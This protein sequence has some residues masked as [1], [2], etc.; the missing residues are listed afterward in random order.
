MKKALLVI[1]LISILLMGAKHNP[2]DLVRLTVVNKSGYRIAVQLSGVD[3]TNLF[4]YLTLPKG[5]KDHPVSQT[6]TIAASRYTAKVFYIEIYDPVYGYDC[7]GGASAKIEADRNL[8]FTIL[9]C[10][11][12]IPRRNRG[13]PSMRKFS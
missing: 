11:T 7:G 10:G 4:Y 12:R 6:F 2:V 13:E 8:R 1:S 5:E 3:N 9:T